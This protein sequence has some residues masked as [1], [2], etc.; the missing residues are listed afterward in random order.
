MFYFFTKSYKW[1]RKL[2]FRILPR[3]YHTFIFFKFNARPLTSTLSTSL[4]QSSFKLIFTPEKLLLDIIILASSAYRMNLA[5]FEIWGMSLMYIMKNN[6]PNMLP[7]GTPYSMC[8]T[9]SEDQYLSYLHHRS[10]VNSDFL[11]VFS[12]VVSRYLCQIPLGM[13]WNE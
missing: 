7:W 13:V 6:G 1:S 5:I 4:L 11:I 9:F 10:L 3:E 12:L 2:P 8:F